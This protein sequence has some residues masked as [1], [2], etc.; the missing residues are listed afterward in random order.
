M[1]LS[2]RTSFSL[3][4][5]L[6]GLKVGLYSQLSVQPTYSIENQSGIY[7]KVPF[8]KWFGPTIQSIQDRFDLEDYNIQLDSVKMVK[9]LS[10]VADE[11][12]TYTF[13]EP[14]GSNLKRRPLVIFAHGGAFL[15]GGRESRGI[16]FLAEEFAKRGYATASIEY[17]LKGIHT[18]SLLEA[19]Y[20]AMQ[21]GNAAVKYFRANA[22]RFNFD[23]DRIF[24]AG[25]SAGG[26]LALHTGHFEQGE[27]LLGRI[28]DLDS[29]YG[30]FDCTGDYPTAKSNVAGVIN[31]VG[32]TPTP[33]ILNADL[34]TLH[35]YCPH[36][37]IVPSKQGIPLNNFGRGN[38]LTR[39]YFD[40][41]SKLDLPIVFGAEYLKNNFNHS[42]HKYVDISTYSNTCNHNLLIA[43]NGTVKN[44]G[45]EI[46]R[47]I[48]EWLRNH[49]GPTAK[50]PIVKLNLN[51]W[52]TLSLPDDI[53]S[54]E[55]TS[56]NNVKYKPTSKNEFEIMPQSE[57]IASFS[58][59]FS[60]DLGLS[61]NF[62]VKT[63][64]EKAYEN[65]IS[66]SIE[67]TGSNYLVFAG[68]F[69]TLIFVIIMIRKKL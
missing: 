11:N 34:P 38:P 45:K 37:T 68:F 65:P 29:K 36:D 19:G 13:Y 12:L 47:I 54:F 10:Q 41:L 49:L 39:W 15:I 21:D 25:I 48:D 14:V 8:V 20:M 69:A 3:F 6:F 58:V 52:T 51:R 27:D 28:Q 4:I 22:S 35:I 31:I 62:D 42:Q 43:K 53:V 23:P 26:F 66:D 59:E 50:R 32:A 40:L 17:R 1:K 33:D 64:V 2:I 55:V 24:I 57:G 67:G 61:G 44:T 46:V 63:T 9:I 60:N 5:C 56:L 18:F 7:S 16:T 30:C